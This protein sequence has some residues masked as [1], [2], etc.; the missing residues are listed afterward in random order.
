M[1][2]NLNNVKISG[3]RRFFNKVKKVDGA[4]SLTLGQPDFKTPKE[5]KYGMIKAIEEDKTVYTDNFGLLELR[6]E[7]STYLNRRGINYSMEEICITVGGSEALYSSISSLINKNDKVLIP[8]PSYPAYENI[9]NILG[10]EVIS[11]NLNNDFSINFNEL[12]ELLKKEDIKYLVLSYPCNPTGAV[13]KKNEYN[14]LIDLIRRYNLIVVTDEIYEAFCYDNYYSVAMCNEIKENI[15][16]IGGFSKMFSITG[17]RIGFIAAAEKYLKEIAKVH[18]YNV[19]CT[20]S[21]GQ[22]GVLEGLKYG[23]YNVEK[24]KEEFINRK[25]Y[26][27]NR[28]TAMGLECFS[29]SGAFYIFPSIKQFNISSEEFCENLL[30]EEKVACVPGSAFGSGGEGYVRISYCY[31]IEELEIAL[32]S[33]EKY[34]N[35]LY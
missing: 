6:K 4:I 2:E 19:S 20:N 7:I 26:V 12:N 3:I 1:N 14:K 11:Y 13:L 34:I 31:S 10:G 17:I 27:E 15:I 35:T 22:Y 16:Y 18:Q 30:K 5:I 8:N 21:I 29:P 33:L 32:N 9:V 28:L 23:L 25:T 24:M